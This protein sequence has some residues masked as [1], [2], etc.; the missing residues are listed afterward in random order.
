MAGKSAGD[1]VSAAGQILHPAVRGLE[2][3]A[4]GHPTIYPTGVTV[5]DPT[6][7]WSG[8]TIFPAADLGALLID[9]NGKEVQLWKDLQGFP[10][11]LLPHGQ[12]FGS[13]GLSRPRS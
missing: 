1:A 3:K 12:V 4:M 2:E 13:T 9:M 8:Y 7:A 11:K 10:N 6:K 5:Y